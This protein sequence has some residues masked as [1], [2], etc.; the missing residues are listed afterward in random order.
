MNLESETCEKLNMG[1]RVPG[2]NGRSPFLE[3]GER[4]T[5]GWIGVDLDGT[6]AKS[7]KSHAAE[8]IGVPIY[9]MVKQVKKW[10][11]EG[12]EVRIS[13]PA[14]IPITA[15]SRLCALVGPLKLGLNATLDKFFP[16][17]TRRIGTWFCCSTTERVKLS[18]IP[19][20]L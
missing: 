4:R 17:L 12:Q 8:D 1:K 14:L 9:R 7:V 2:N 16:S 10:L 20:G 11:A 13:P 5:G 18:G 15:E 6:L 19:E 3:D